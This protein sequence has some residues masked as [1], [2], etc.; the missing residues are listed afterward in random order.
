MLSATSPHQSQ[1]FLPVDDWSTADQTGINELVSKISGYRRSFEYLELLRFMARFRDYAPYNCFLLHMQNP[2]IGYVATVNDWLYRFN[3]RV[4]LDARA[5]VILKPWGPVQFVY[6]LSDTVGDNQIFPKEILQPFQTLGLV[7]PDMWHYTIQ[8]C[9][10]D[11]IQVVQ[12][13]SSL[14]EAGRAIRLSSPE[15]SQQ[16]KMPDIQYRVE[17][18]KELDL[19]TRYTTLIHELGH[20]Y[21]G[22]L[23]AQRKNWWSDRSSL[24]TSIEEFEAESIAYLIGKRLGLDSQSEKYLIGYLSENEEIP[25]IS[26]KIILDVVSAIEKMGRNTFRNAKK[27][28][29]SRKGNDCFVDVDEEMHQLNLF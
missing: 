3:R 19:A 22:H 7:S 15:A 27:V 8:A 20:I 29:D 6:D 1:S 25:K 13:S 28:K 23:G 17:V 16:S 9:R 24:P 21:A 12:L 4:K 14:K 5:L 2:H 11:G 18:N 26:F 10:R